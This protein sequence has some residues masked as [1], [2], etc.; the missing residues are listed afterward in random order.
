MCVGRCVFFFRLAACG[1]FAWCS[2]LAEIQQRGAARNS[3]GEGRERRRE[4]ERRER[5]ERV[6]IERERRGRAKE[7]R[8][9]GRDRV[10]GRG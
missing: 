9:E 3:E 6:S 2:H 4:R 5:W 7:E 8:R 1:P 10:I